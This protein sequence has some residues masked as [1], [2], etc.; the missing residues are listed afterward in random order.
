MT[1]LALELKKLGH[2]ITVLT[3]TP[4]YNVEPEARR[5]QP[6]SPKWVGLLYR[7]DC[8]IPV[9][10]VP[11]REKGARVVSRL[12]DYVRFHVMS[13]IAGLVFNES[14]D[15]ILAPSP[16]L[17]IGLSA[18][19]LG[20]ARHVPFIYNVQEIY[21]DL[22]VSLNLIRNKYLIR[23]MELMERFIY[24]QAKMNVVISEWFKERLLLKGVKSNKISTIPN[25]VNVDFMR[26]SNKNNNFAK[27]YELLKK[28]VVLYA[29]NIGMTQSFETV[30]EAAQRLVYIEEIQFVI[31]GN[32]VRL[33]WLNRELSKNFVTNIKLLPYQPQS[34]V[35]FIYASSDVCLIPLK[36]GTA[37][38]TFPSKIYTIMASGRPAIVSA[39][40]DSELAWIVERAKCGIV[41]PPDDSKALA[42]A[43]EYAF[44]QPIRLGEMGHKGREYVV[45]HHSHQSVAL[46]YHRLISEILSSK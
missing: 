15:V 40:K 20:S 27:N 6:L 35:P 43:V 8:G 7:S 34:M 14:Y 30:I 1:E 37:Q 26:P 18:W 13:T 29:G 22:A 5:K 32:G 16:P 25:F 21:P 17:T 11:V 39:D 45:Q 19:I 38:E 41:V 9:Y 23:M 3:T 4:H 42:N 46:Q 2:Q 33:E 12:I 36:K 28:F 44:H 10:H 31:L 24:D